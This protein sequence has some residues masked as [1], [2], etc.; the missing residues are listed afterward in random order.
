MAD[1]YCTSCGEPWDTHTLHEEA[2]ARQADGDVR[3]YEEILLEVSHDFRSRGC[4]ALAAN[5][6]SP[7][8]RSESPAMQRTADGAAAIYE[9]LG[10]EEIVDGAAFALEDYL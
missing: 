5:G 10:D 4:V 1:I 8:R 9:L 2:G 7:C 3:S 6:A